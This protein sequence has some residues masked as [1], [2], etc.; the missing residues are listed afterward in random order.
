MRIAHSISRVSMVI[1]SE[2]MPSTATMRIGRSIRVNAA[3]RGI[4]GEKCEMMIAPDLNL[5]RTTNEMEHDA[6][7]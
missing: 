1:V 7:G 5:R 6:A 4:Q 3:G 2:V